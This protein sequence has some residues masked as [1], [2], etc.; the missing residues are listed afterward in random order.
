MATKTINT[1]IKFRR[2]NANQWAANYILQDGEPGFELDTGKL[3]IGN[4]ITQW[5]ELEY[6][7]GKIVLTTNDSL[8]YYGDDLLIKGQY[9]ANVGQVP[10]KAQDGAI[11]WITPLTET[12]ITNSTALNNIIEG[13][14]SDINS[15][16]YK[17]E[18]YEVLTDDEVIKLYND[19]LEEITGELNDVY[20]YNNTNY[21]WNG[22]EWV[23]LTNTS[24]YATSQEM[25]AL[26][27]RVTT[28][29]NGAITGLASAQDAG[30]VKSSN[31]TNKIYV[32]VDG[33]MSVNSIGIDK[34]VDNGYTL[35]LNNGQST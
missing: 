1:I 17:G 34:L 19:N 20:S 16:T 6:V 31:S 29:E 5:S 28:L 30:A 24:P 13:K 15:R 21:I 33:T 22:T 10:S 4:G 11:T 9:L 14:I 2:A 25:N 3:K 7:K 35:I 18:A 32:E 26:A 8:E 27:S 12:N 23:E